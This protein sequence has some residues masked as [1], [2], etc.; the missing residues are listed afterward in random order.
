[1]TWLLDT[2]VLSEYARKAPAQRVIDWLDEQEEE[3]LFISA[4]SLGEIGKGI[5]KLRATDPKRSQKLTGWLG[6]VEQRFTGRT[7]PL[8]TAAYQAWARLAAEAELA[9]Q[10]LPL[11]D[12]LLMATA[13]CHGL[14][15]VTR[16][17][18]DFL[19]FPHIFNPWD[20]QP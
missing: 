6:T 4:I 7:L 12:A 3:R 8:D 13:H 19:S 20:L 10:P 11:M 5:L 17:T 9:G 1:M 14:T 2:C 15:I 16:N 18:R